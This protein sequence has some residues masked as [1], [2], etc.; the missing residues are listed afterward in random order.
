MVSTVGTSTV[1]TAPEDSFQRK[2]FYAA[3]RFWVFWSDGTNIVWATS[4]DGI[5]WSA[6]QTAIAGVQG[7]LFSLWY[8]KARN[9]VHFVYCSGAQNASLWYRR[10]EPLSNGNITFAFDWQNVGFHSNCWINFPTVGVD[11]DGY[12]YIGYRIYNGSSVLAFC[13]KSSTNDGTWTTAAGFPYQLTTVTAG[14]REYFTTVVPL[15]SK[16]MLFVFCNYNNYYCYSREYD[17]AGN[18]GAIELVFGGTM[19]YYSYG[20]IADGDDAHI[21]FLEYVAPNAIVYHEKR[22]HGVGWGA[23]TDVSGVVATSSYPCASISNGILYAFWLGPTAKKAYYRIRNA[24][25]TW[26][27]IVEWFTETDDF[28]GG[29]DSENCFQ[30]S[31]GSQIGMAFESK[32][33]SPYNIRFAFI[34]TVSAP[35]VLTAAATNI[36]EY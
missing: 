1:A 21:V 25:G 8:D 35:T 14:T 27:S 18:W 26:N 36:E 15:L 23:A 12:P 3:G 29:F 4:T 17:G 32:T 30:E 24:N 28:T 9:F 11:S 7:Y 19:Y 10:G 5:T 22:T 33:V 34:Q 2:S 16:K 13:T 31:L 20:V 6:K